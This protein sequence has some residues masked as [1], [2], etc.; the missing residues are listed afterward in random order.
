MVVLNGTMSR[1][2]QIKLSVRQ[3]STLGPWLCMLYIYDLA[4]RVLDSKV[5]ARISSLCC[6]SY[7]QADD[8]AL[9]SL[10]VNGL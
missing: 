8:S 5:G 7:L 3:G 9:A 6:G 2:I 4:V 1:D 10:T